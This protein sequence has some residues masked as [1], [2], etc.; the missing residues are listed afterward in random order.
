MRITLINMA[1]GTFLLAMIFFVWMPG[2]HAL[3]MFQQNRYELKRYIPWM[4]KAITDFGAKLALYLFFLSPLFLL[5]FIEDELYSWITLTVIVSLYALLLWKLE[6]RKQYIKPLSLTNRV[7][8]QIVV[9]IILFFLITIPL[10]LWLPMRGWLIMVPV[11]YWLPWV[12]VLVM[13]FITEP[14]ENFV[15]NYYIYLAKRILRKRDNLIK[16]GITGSYGKTSSKNILNDI[17][18]N[19]FYSL[20]TPASYNTP[21]GITITIRTMLKPIHQVFIC[22]MGADK[23]GEID[24]L[25]KFVKPQFGIVTSIGPQ[26]L[27]TFKTLDN[28]INEKMKM[29]ENLPISG[30]GVLNR[31]NEHIRNYRIKNKCQILWY[32]IE[33]EDVDYRAVNIRYSPKGTSFEVITREQVSIPFE[34]KMLGEHSVLNILAAIA[35]G[36][37]LGIDWERL[38]KAVAT[39]RQ[40][41]HRLEVKKMN[42]YT[43]IDNAFN[44]NPVSSKNS[45]DILSLMPGKRIVMTPGMIELGEKQDEYNRAFGAMMKGK[46]DVVL[47]IGKTQ[48]LPIVEGLKES[49]YD[50]EQV[51]VLASVKE[52]FAW[53]STHASKDDT[54]LIENDLPDAFSR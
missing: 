6:K 15:K 7:R 45:L 2:K 25:T 30:V 10:V 29:I 1:Q 14:I 26:H 52:A 9:M 43:V 33:N 8:R 11:F 16:I 5:L 13:A 51:V 31:D 32:G 28:I 27:N 49:G 54:V 38:Q 37:H 22:E 53:L 19:Q 47:L 42:G 48:T 20:M 17:L 3:H 24:M 18:T 23:V 50:M 21:M 41:E 4:S 40:V 34:T 12:M 46:A 35:L 44:S 36:K 39:T